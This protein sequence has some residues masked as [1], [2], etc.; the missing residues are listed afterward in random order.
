MENINFPLIINN[1]EICGSSH[2][3]TPYGSGH[4]H[5]TFRVRN[6]DASCPDYLLQ[7]IN[8]RAFKKVPELMVNMDLVTSH[9]R[10]KLHSEDQIHFN[11]ETLTLIPTINSSYYYHD[12]EGS[13]W[14]IFVFIPD[15]Q[16]FDLVESPQQA[17]L[18]GKTFGNFQA[19]L[20]DMDPQMLHETIPDFHNVERRLLTFYNTLMVDPVHRVQKVQPEIDFIIERAE[21]MTLINR[22]G[23]EGKIPLRITHND[24]KFN[25]ILFDKNGNSL[26]VIDLDTVMPGYVAYDFGD[27]IRTTINT[28]AED[29][30]DLEKIQIDLS[31]FE[32]YAKG[33]LEETKDFLNPVEIDHLV[34]GAKLLSYLMGL[35]FLTDYLDGDKYYKIHFPEQNLQR[36]RAQYQLI[37]KMEDNYENMQNIIY[38]ILNSLN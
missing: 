11:R 25:N 8:D 22:L 29:E 32:A 19:L 26:C 33:F 5:D 31:L 9:L 2:K 23:R 4:I 21:T 14:R 12:A 24:T 30:K 36:A 28:A 34:F 16:S 20:S 15:T 7:R 35:R 17:Y 6:A 3:V 10:K 27:S 18:G 1:F 13:F 38:S 37:R